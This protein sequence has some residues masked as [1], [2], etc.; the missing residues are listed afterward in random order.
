[1]RIQL[2]LVGQAGAFFVLRLTVLFTTT[3][4]SHPALAPEN[5]QGLWVPFTDVSYQEMFIFSLHGCQP[6]GNVH[7]FYMEGKKRAFILCIT[8]EMCSPTPPTVEEDTFQTSDAFSHPVLS[9]E[10]IN[11]VCS[12]GNWALMCCFKCLGE[13]T[14]VVSDIPFL[15]SVVNF[16]F[17]LWGGGR[18]DRDGEHM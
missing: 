3:S 5:F 7:L 1:M 6:P 12:L 13:V 15:F 16:K 2:V 8:S 11:K 17:S 4:I 10:F 14:I 18:G 9:A